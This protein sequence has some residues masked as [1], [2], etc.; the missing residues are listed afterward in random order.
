MLK[1]FRTMQWHLP[2]AKLNFVS[3][4]ARGKPAATFGTTSFRSAAAQSRTS[5]TNVDNAFQTVSAALG[6]EAIE[7]TRAS[8]QLRAVAAQAAQTLNYPTQ[9]DLTVG[10]VDF[11]AGVRNNIQILGNLGKD[12]DYKVLA[13][14]RLATFTIAIRNKSR[15]SDWYVSVLVLIYSQMC[16]LM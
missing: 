14:N 6:L 4:T 9:D 5:R 8:Q 3:L 10:E 1:I 13:S 16:K 15:E 7:D 12:V 2:H 11:D